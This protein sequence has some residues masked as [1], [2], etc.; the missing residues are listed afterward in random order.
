MPSLAFDTLKLATE[1][2]DK[3]G[4]SYPQAEGAAEAI[5]QAIEYHV[6]TKDDIEA[7]KRDMLLAIAN[8]QMNVIRKMVVM[9]GLQTL[10]IIATVLEISRQIK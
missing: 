9:A 2:R 1:L 6:A 4:L 3:A 8:A 10:V 5:T 7:L